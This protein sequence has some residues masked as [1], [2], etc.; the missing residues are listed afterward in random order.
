MTELTTEQLQAL[1]AEA[2]RTLD[3]LLENVEGNAE[4]QSAVRKVMR[5]DGQEVPAFER[6]IAEEPAVANQ[7]LFSAVGAL[8]NLQALRTVKEELA[9]R[10]AGN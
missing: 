10:A 4:L 2:H 5:A 3:A 9:K 1:Q 7:L 6:L 8:A